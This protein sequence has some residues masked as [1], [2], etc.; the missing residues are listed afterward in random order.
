MVNT[1]ATLFQKQGYAATGWRQVIA[2]SET[3]WGSQSHHFPDG[4]EELAVEAIERSGAIYAQ[5]VRQVFASGHPA[6]SMRSWSVLAGQVLEQSAWAEGCPVATVALELAHTCEP[7]GEAC[8]DALRSWRAGIAA[9]LIAAG[10]NA[11]RADE[12]AMVILA[13]VEGALLLA[14]VERSSDPLRLVG[15]DLASRLE[16]EFPR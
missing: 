9:G 2:D 16:V 13:S 5:L 7:V 1:A 4:K 8:R 11:S 10:A 14:R 6:D 12:L 15:E 3:P